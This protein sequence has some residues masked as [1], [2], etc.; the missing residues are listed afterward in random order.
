[1][2]I[3]LTGQLD[4]GALEPALSR[5]GRASLAPPDVDLIRGLSAHPSRHRPG[6]EIQAE[7]QKLRAPMLVVSGWACLA[8]DLPDGR[9]QIFRLLLP[10]DVIGIA[11]YP[12]ALSLANVVALTAVTT[13]DATALAEAMNGAFGASALSERLDQIAAEDTR[14]LLNQILR[15]GPMTRRETVAN[16]LL[17][18]YER[19]EQVGLAADDR[20]HLPITQTMLADAVGTSS[21]HLNRILSGLRDEGLIELRSA[22]VH[23]LDR[24]SLMA[25]CHFEPRV[26]PAASARQLLSQPRRAAG[27]TPR[28]WAPV[29]QEDH[30]RA[31]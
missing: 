20:L 19:L 17:E 28:S 8:R 4:P 21:V 1:M 6:A 3:R 2:G 5:L 25:M 23:F 7:G 13:V 30:V 31:S 10:G 15:L 22:H 12:G 14:L 29:V 18:L 9:R 11:A 27:H 16:L 26:E 24:E